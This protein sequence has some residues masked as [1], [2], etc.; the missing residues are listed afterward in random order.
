M[1]IVFAGGGTGGHLY[2]GLAIARALVRLEPTVRP[3]FVGA[4]RGIERDVLP[5]SEF[6]HLL[7]DLHPLYR[8]KPLEN[9]RTLRGFV[10][11]WRG[12]GAMARGG[13]FRAA[14]SESRCSESRRN[15]STRIE[16]R[17]S[18]SARA[19]ASAAILAAAVSLTGGSAGTAPGPGARD[20]RPQAAMRNTTLA[21]TARVIRFVITG[22][23]ER[24]IGLSSRVRW[25]RC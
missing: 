21:H 24:R 25:R 14:N 16:S 10:S 3:F 23:V 12:I 22:R 4:R 19:F 11:A 7:L 2:P 17:C 9:W 1:R 8:A 20:P 5:T 18:E 13:A 6:P 15:E